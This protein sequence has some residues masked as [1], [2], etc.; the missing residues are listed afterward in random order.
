[1]TDEKTQQKNNAESAPPKANPKGNILLVDDD[2][3]LLDMY[4]MKFAALGFTVQSA[5]SVMDA[6]QALR[7]G[8]VADAIVFDLIM[9]EHDGFSFLQSL[10]SEKL[11][12]GAALIALTNEIEE[13]VKGKVTEL[14]GD[15]LITKAT[16]IPSEVVEVVQG[17]IEKKKK[18]K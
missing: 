4:S 3:F 16:M 12:K 18:A 1:M 8:F 17:E 9:P 7:N 15:R 11:A 6:L 5:L 14:G 10:G 13:N 2:K